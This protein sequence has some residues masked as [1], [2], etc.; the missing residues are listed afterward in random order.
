ML[1]Y[2]VIK[3]N[4]EVLFSNLSEEEASYALANLEDTGTKG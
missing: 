1:R 3:T 4:V 2:R